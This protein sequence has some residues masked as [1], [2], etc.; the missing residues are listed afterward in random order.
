MALSNL[1][2]SPHYYILE[3]EFKQ[4]LLDLEPITE[5][6]QAPVF[7]KGSFV[8]LFFLLKIVILS[9]VMFVVFENAPQWFQIKGPVPDFKWFETHP[10]FFQHI[11]NLASLQEEVGSI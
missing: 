5:L 11:R 10:K 6:Q 2:S 9:H 8:S 4:W 3:S 7:F 1:F